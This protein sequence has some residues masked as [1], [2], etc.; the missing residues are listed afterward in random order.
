MSCPFKPKW[1][2]RKE[3]RPQ[4][5]LAAALDLFVE[6]GFAATR[7]DDVAR[8]AGVSKGTL[9]LYFSSK[10][11]LFK[12]VVRESIVPMI[13]EA[14]GVIDAF[15][16]H[17]E[18]LFRNVMHR[19]WDNVGNTKLSGL[20]KLMMGEAGN[21]PELARFYQDEVVN[22]GERMV[23]TMLRRGMARGEIRDVDLEI[24]ARLLIAPMI[25]MMMWKHSAGVC[26][27]APE[28]LDVY[29]EHYIEMALHG[30]LIRR[31]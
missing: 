28:K 16:G 22:R 24:D 21:F 7:L 15:E 23:A 6:R 8:A 20:P 27:V 19:W 3:A 14:E 4:E 11:D 9:Y 1:E 13:G 18:E 29:L 31:A 26:E 17:T 10:E 2:R 30:L 25:M 12:A 5:L